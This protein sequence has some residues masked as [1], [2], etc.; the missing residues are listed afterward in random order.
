M[1]YC[2]SAVSSIKQWSRSH[3]DKEN[4]RHNWKESREETGNITVQY[5]TPVHT[6]VWVAACN[7][8]PY[9]S[10]LNWNGYVQLKAWQLSDVRYIFFMK[11]ARRQEFLN[12]KKR[13]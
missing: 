9:S 10:D 4:C 11:E 13:F 7:F 1:S 8:V 6:Q 12:L 5:E 3:E 2:Y